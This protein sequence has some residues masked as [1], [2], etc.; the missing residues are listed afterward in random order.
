MSTTSAQGVLGLAWAAGRIDFAEPGIEPNYAPSRTVVIEHV[1][2]RLSLW[3]Q[4]RRY[5]GS[6]RIRLRGLPTHDGS[7]TLDLGPVDDLVV[8]DGNGVRL[9]WKR[10]D[11]RVRVLGE[12]P[13]AVVLTWNGGQPE[14]GLYFTGPT[15]WSPDRPPVAWTQCQ[16]EDGHAFFPCHDHPGVKHPW[17]IE[18]EG[19]A[20]Y[21]LLSNGACV[22][23]REEGGRVVTVWDQRDPMPAYLFTAVASVRMGDQRL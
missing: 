18:L 11:E 5:E 9:K 19:P 10:E 16:D 15:E 14:R 2:L 1:S 13:E 17:K 8:E 12:V 20:G 6:A 4:E 22:E 21:T 7:F 3:P 23:T